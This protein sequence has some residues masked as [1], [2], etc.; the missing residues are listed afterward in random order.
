MQ[1][2]IYVIVYPFLWVISKLP[3]KLIYILSDAVY[4]LVYNVFAYRKK[5]VVNNLKLAFPDYSKS[6]HEAIAKKFYKH[7]CDMIFEAI[8]SISISKE[9]AEKRFQLE[10]LSIFSELEKKNKSAVLI[11]GHYGNWEWIFIL[12]TFINHKGYGIYKRL[13]NKYFDRLVK[14]IRAKYDTYLIT[15]KETVKVLNEVNAKGELTVSGFISD[16]SPKRD[17]AF[18][19]QE[20]M[21]VEVPVYTGA[22]MMAKKLDH[23]VVFTKISKVKRGHYKCSFELIT[24]Q[25]K[26]IPDYKITDQ[27]LTLLEKQIHEE[28]AYY[29]WTHK[30][31][32]HRKV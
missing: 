11:L 15:T 27:F 24:D 8:K 9:E 28:P 20:F 7:L 17:K 31:W 13:K 25:P 19:W 26:L 12:Q 2:L 23:A 29:L 14:R 1:L 6:Q 10:N 5:V 3:F 30:R 22:E 21:G 16:Q 18:H 4:I 32:K